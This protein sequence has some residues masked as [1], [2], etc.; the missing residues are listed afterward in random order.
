VNPCPSSCVEHE[1]SR[2]VETGEVSLGNVLSPDV[3]GRM[4]VVK[5]R[6]K[7]RVSLLLL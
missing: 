1:P 7:E 3:E 4:K 2:Q 5:L 6:K